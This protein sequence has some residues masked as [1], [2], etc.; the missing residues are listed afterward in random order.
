MM[1]RR[2]VSVMAP[3]HPG[4]VEKEELKPGAPSGDGMSILECLER[5]GAEDYA[6]P[7]PPALEEVVDWT[8]TCLPSQMQ[9]RIGCR[10]VGM[11]RDNRSPLMRN[12]CLFH[13]LRGHR[14]ERRKA[15]RSL[16][17]L[18]VRRPPH[19]SLQ[20]TPGFS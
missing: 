10:Q 7:V 20:E 19:P 1:L 6:V 12:S 5:L 3:L 9:R 8:E 16:V 17:R 11:K 13:F 14:V 15:Q 2:W 18:L 4:L